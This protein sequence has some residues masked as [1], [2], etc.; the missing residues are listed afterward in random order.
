MY[1]GLFSGFLPLSV[2]FSVVACSQTSPTPTPHLYFS[3]ISSSKSLGRQQVM[4]EDCVMLGT[5]FFI[6]HTQEHI[7]LMP[8]CSPQRKTSQQKTRSQSKKECGRGVKLLPNASVPRRNSSLWV[9]QI[10][11]IIMDFCFVFATWTQKI[12]LRHHLPV[13]V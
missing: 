6:Y 5:A 8:Y 2:S 11:K 9:I 7:S 3:S 4:E 13:I 12:F 1:F 10:R